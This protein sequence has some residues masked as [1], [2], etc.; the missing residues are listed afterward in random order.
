[1]QSWCSGQLNCNKP[2]P[3]TSRCPHQSRQRDSMPQTVVP[4]SVYTVP[5]KLPTP[6]AFL[7]LDGVMVP[8]RTWG[9]GGSRRAEQSPADLITSGCRTGSGIMSVL[10]HFATV[11]LDARRHNHTGTDTELCGCSIYCEPL[12]TSDSVAG[13]SVCM[14]TG[15]D[16][17]C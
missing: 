4:Y 6:F 5:N 14:C 11:L 13:M 2:V 12:C 9:S 16:F 7:S 10:R 8:R 1:M 17:R 15:I 3:M